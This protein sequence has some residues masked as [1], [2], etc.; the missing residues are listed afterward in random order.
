M[1]IEQDQPMTRNSRPVTER[2][3]FGEWIYGGYA[4]VAGGL[5]VLLFGSLIAILGRLRGRRLAR[6]ATRLIFRVA[7][8][9]LSASGIDRLPLTPHILVVNHTSFLDGLVLSALLPCEPG[10]AFVVRQQYRSQALLWPLLKGL[11]TIVLRHSVAGHK[12]ANVEILV[13]ALA[14]GN[15]ILVFPEGGFVPEPGLR[16]FHS[17]AFR[18]ASRA[19]VPTVVAGLDGVRE[20]LRPGTWWPRQRALHLEIGSTIEPTSDDPTTVPEL[21]AAA[22][23]AMLAITKEG[24]ASQAGLQAGLPVREQHLP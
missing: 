24:D 17:G 4:W 1:P 15:N 19:R 18:A 6:F 16:P 14:K 13:A 12:T 3:R 10:Y 20:A 5:L 23:R 2:R 21:A 22:H 7:H 11:G 9:P 8:M